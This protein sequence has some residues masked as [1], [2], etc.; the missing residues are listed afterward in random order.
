MIRI[1]HNGFRLALAPLLL[2]FWGCDSGETSPT[3]VADPRAIALKDSREASGTYE[4]SGVTVQANNGRLREISGTIWLRV[5][6]PR[7]AVEFNLDTTVPDSEKPA[8]VTGTGSGM[9]VGGV[10]TG[11][12]AEEISGTNPETGE[13]LETGGLKIVSTSR[14]H[15]DESGVFEI[16]LQNAPAE[17]Q[18]YSPSIT[19]LSGRRTGPLPDVA[20]PFPVADQSANR[21]WK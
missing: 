9:I 12:T 19:G 20:A 7:Y 1:R 16:Q 5:D 8:Q 4:V 2:T 13:P 14:A 17:G 11:A 15:F 21:M 3:Y 18:D 10:F 6:G